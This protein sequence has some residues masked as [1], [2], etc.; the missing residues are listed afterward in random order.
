ML[1]AMPCYMIAIVSM[2][3]AFQVE[4]CSQLSSNIAPGTAPEAQDCSK[5]PSTKVQKTARQKE[6]CSQQLSSKANEPSTLEKKR[7]AKV[8]A[9][10]SKMTFN[11]PTMVQILSLVW[12]HQPLRD[13]W[14]WM[15]LTEF[16]PPLLPLC[17]PLPPLSSLLPPF[18]NLRLQPSIL[19]NASCTFLYD[20]L[21]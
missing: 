14:Y 8:Q 6:G 13:L 12:T 1:L 21:T 16:N 5:Q 7:Q 18:G 11:A 2:C 4:D 17:P 10:A 9:K 20:C 15:Q 19:C 3:C